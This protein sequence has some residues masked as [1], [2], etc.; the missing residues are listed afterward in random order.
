MLLFYQLVTIVAMVAITYLV[1]QAFGRP[2]KTLLY[3]TEEKQQ[4]DTLIAQPIGSWFTKTNVVGTLT[5]FATV[6]L[7]FIG[8]SKLFGWW[9]LL[10]SVGIWG[11]SFVTN[12][13]T[14]AICRD[15]FIQ[16]LIESP[17]Q[18]GGVIASVF[19]RPSSLP[20]QRTAA[21]A[22]WL[23]LLNI[24]GIVWLDFALFAD[25]SGR[26]LG[27]THLWARL[28]LLL[29]C[30]FTIFYFTFRYGL[31]GFVFADLFQV[32]IVVLASVGILAGCLYLTYI[33][34]GLHFSIAALALPVLRTKECVLFGAHVLFLNL[35]FVLVTEPHWLRLWIFRKKEIDLQVSAVAWTAGIWIVLMMV[36]FLASFHSGGKLGEDAV[37]GLLFR[38]NQISPV[39]S[40]LFWLGGIAAL[41]SSADAQIYSFL[42]VREFDL[43]TGRLR[44]RLMSTLSPF[45]L[46]LI[47]AALFGV[48]YFLLRSF[49]VPFEK[50]IF[51]VIPLSLNIFPAL[52]LAGFH[53][54]PK[55]GYIL[56][57]LSLYMACTILGLRQPDDNFLWTLTAALVPLVVGVLALAVTSW[58][59][60][61][62]SNREITNSN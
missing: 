41:F 43:R 21:L 14:K 28:A 12:Y 62:R 27:L 50:I 5:A 49:E 31:R 4:W 58:T 40:V 33:S 2:R 35:V 9:I 30:C 20:A 3:S 60:S 10:C 19:W 29:F 13:V 6:Y 8:N 37:V 25:I 53:L 47:A 54:P 18:A 32:P 45:A 23:S 39:F 17:D 42:V 48:A 22:K 52:L 55:P 15:P 36:G 57:S 44:A 38:L 24:L 11:G 59:Q 26:L 16:E 61:R 56:L 7:F 34:G 51:L 1:F 46:S